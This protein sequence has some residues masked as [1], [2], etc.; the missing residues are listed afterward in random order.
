MV[1]VRGGLKAFGYNPKLIMEMLKCDLGIALFQGTQPIFFQNHAKEPLIPYEL[2]PLIPGHRDIDETDMSWDPTYLK[3]N[4][5][6][7]HAWT[8]MRNFCSTINSVTERKRRLSKEILLNTMASVMYRLL[9]LE[10]FDHNSLDEAVRLG[11]LAF[12]YLVFLRFENVKLPQRHF[13]QKYWACLQSLRTSEVPSD[14]RLWLFVIGAIAFASPDDDTSSLALL[15]IDVKSYGAY[16]LTESL[17]LLRHFLWIEI[18]V[19]SPG[20]AVLESL[21]S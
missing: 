7:V 9:A 20:K 15:R 17:H 14:L 18:L 1:D 12:S 13:P 8:A 4:T 2:G 19:Q 11:L 16:Q 3:I 10:S 21:R 6:L 5:D